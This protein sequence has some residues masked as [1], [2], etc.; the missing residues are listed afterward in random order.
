MATEFLS[1]PLDIEF[2]HPAKIPKGSSRKVSQ[3]PSFF[4]ASNVMMRMG[5]HHEDDFGSSASPTNSDPLVTEARTKSATAADFS[6]SYGLGCD[7]SDEC[8]ALSCSP[9][10]YRRGAARSWRQRRA[11]RSSDDEE[12][13]MTTQRRSRASNGDD[14][15]RKNAASDASRTYRLGSSESAQHNSCSALDALRRRRSTESDDSDA[16]FHC[17]VNPP[18]DELK[19][20]RQRGSS[21]ALSI[22]TTMSDAEIDE[23]LN[24]PDPFSELSLGPL[25][26]E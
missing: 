9:R 25:E 3:C 21:A 10:K 16:S 5:D 26:E 23:F 22:I 14:Y 20:T 24:S 13:L 17:E 11:M 8:K 12:E 2:L 7:V 6:T 18:I 4:D 19:E 1:T 15:P